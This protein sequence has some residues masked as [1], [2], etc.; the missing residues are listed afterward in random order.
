MNFNFKNKVKLFIFYSMQ[1]QTFGIGPYL[2]VPFLSAI[3]MT[4]IIFEL[5]T[6]EHSLIFTFML[7]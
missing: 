7:D 6:V 4:E 5:H 2:T 3:L 1:K